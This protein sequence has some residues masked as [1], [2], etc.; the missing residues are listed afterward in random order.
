MEKSVS[1]SSRSLYIQEPH[2]L[3]FTLLSLCS[4]TGKTMQ[5]SR[6]KEIH[7]RAKAGRPIF[8]KTWNIIFLL[9]Q[10]RCSAEGTNHITKHSISPLPLG[11]SRSPPTPTSPSN[12]SYVRD[13]TYDNISYRCDMTYDNISYIHLI[14]LLVSHIYIDCYINF[15]FMKFLP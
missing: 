15:C 14:T 8:S 12:Q 3:L 9:Y 13:I 5:R 10:Q 2:R 1:R 6:K 11:I 7:G 4:P